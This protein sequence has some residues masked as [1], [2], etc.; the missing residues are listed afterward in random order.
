[1]FGYRCF[2]GIG[3]IWCANFVTRSEVRHKL[4][5]SSVQFLVRTL[6][7][8]KLIWLE[9][10]SHIPTSRLPRCVLFSVTVSGWKMSRIGQSMI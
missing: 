3:R 10:V 4:L 2:P 6:Y 9:H 5:G 8:N 1:M 7:L